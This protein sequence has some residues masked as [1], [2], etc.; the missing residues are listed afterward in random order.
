MSVWLNWI[1]GLMVMKSISC[2]LLVCLLSLLAYAEETQ[3][4]QVE[5]L[6]RELQDSDLDIRSIAATGWYG[7][8]EHATVDKA[9]RMLTDIADAIADEAAEIFQQLDGVQG[10]VAEVRHLQEVS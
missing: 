10:G 1:M 5:R 2:I 4:Q 8:P 9:Q 6:I 7:S 3:E